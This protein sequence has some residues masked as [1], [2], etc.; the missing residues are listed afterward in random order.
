MLDY[1]DG[2]VECPFCGS[3]EF[4]TENRFNL[5]ESKNRNF[6]KAYTVVDSETC[7]VCAE[8][9][10][11]LDQTIKGVRSLGLENQ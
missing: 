9:G 11:V 8:C 7:I 2:F 10:K 4:K 5:R 3:F 6:D 1:N